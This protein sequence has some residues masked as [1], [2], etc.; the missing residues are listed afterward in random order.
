MNNFYFKQN[1]VADLISGLA[2]GCFIG[3][4]LDEA[5]KTTPL[6]L[7][8]CAIFGTAGGFYNFYKDM[9]RELKKEEEKSKK[10]E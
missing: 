5:F 6:M 10:D 3:Y 7:F 2:V 9:M 1:L 8:I 4:F